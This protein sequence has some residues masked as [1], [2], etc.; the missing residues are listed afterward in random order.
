MRVIRNA[1]TCALHGECVVAAPEVF[2]IRDDDE[3]VT[4][5][6]PEPGEEL[7]DSVETAALNCPTAS[8]RIE[9]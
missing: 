8:I 3:V 5:R 1:D 9:D 6:N 7:R 2:E 4:V